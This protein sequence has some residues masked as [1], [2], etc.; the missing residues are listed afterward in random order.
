MIEGTENG[1]GIESIGQ[2]TAAYY[3]EVP[4]YV[5]Q[6]ARKWI[7][8]KKSHSAEL[9]DDRGLGTR[10]LTPSVIISKNTWIAQE[11]ITAAE[12]DDNLGDTLVHSGGPW[13]TF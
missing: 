2:D 6:R 5:P 9:F 10:H 4:Q 3:R 8:S 13:L 1:E 12:T 7:L 11:G